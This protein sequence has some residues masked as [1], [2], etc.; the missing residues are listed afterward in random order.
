MAARIQLPRN[1]RWLELFLSPRTV[2]ERILTDVSLQEKRTISISIVLDPPETCSFKLPISHSLILTEENQK[3]LEEVTWIEE[4]L[5]GIKSRDSTSFFGR[6]SLINTKK[7]LRSPTIS[8]ENIYSSRGIFLWRG[9]RAKPSREEK[10]HRS[11]GVRSFKSFFPR[12]FSTQRRAYFCNIFRT[13]RRP[14]STLHPVSLIF[15][16]TLFL[17]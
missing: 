16:L 13:L 10:R 7:Q 15:L 6:T 14:F 2:I 11:P 3:K 1:R 17:T 8:R 4:K 9:K 12:C 5:G